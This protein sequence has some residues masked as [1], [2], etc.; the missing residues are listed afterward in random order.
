MGT[1]GNSDWSIR[2]SWGLRQ[3]GSGP[4]RGSCRAGNAS[5][6]G[7]RNRSF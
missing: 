2:E 7:G 6:A 3:E 5:P 1:H 4:G